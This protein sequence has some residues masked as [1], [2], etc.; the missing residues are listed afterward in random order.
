MDRPCFTRFFESKKLHAR[1]QKNNSSR[2]SPEISK[3]KIPLELKRKSK[4]KIFL[5]TPAPVVRNCRHIC[6]RPLAFVCG[7][8]GA[9]GIHNILSSANHCKNLLDIYVTMAKGVI[10]E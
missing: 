6:S 2:D 4:P 9:F 10:K 7:G 5:V 3:E 8:G 1:P